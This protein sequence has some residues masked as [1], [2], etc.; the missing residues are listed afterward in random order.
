MT[1]S[2]TSPSTGVPAELNLRDRASYRIGGC[3]EVAWAI[4][5]QMA[6]TM[7]LGSGADGAQAASVSVAA[8]PG[9]GGG[10]WRS[11]DGLHVTLL[12]PG[13][14]ADLLAIQVT[15]VAST[16]ALDVE[17]RG[18]LLLHGALAEREGQGAVL[19]G[20]G[21]AGKSTASGRLPPPWRSLCDDTTLVVRD[22]E[23][24]YWAHPWPTWSRFLWG[25]PGGSW[26][27]Q[28]AVPLKGLFVLVQDEEERAEPVGAGRAATLL[29]EATEQ[30]MAA[31]QR[32]M[33]VDQRRA[34]RLRRFDNICALAKAV[35]CYELH[36]SLTGAFWEEM[37]RALADPRAAEDAA[38]R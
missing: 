29:V 3:D 9:R 20:P 4:V 32:D 38:G 37:E 25:G 28:R 5:A 10:S 13:E 12:D 21:M 31:M 33:T 26:D 2:G 16:I 1:D 11:G 23:G 30:V 8:R 19:A 35:P 15:E 14:S 34:I 24:R 36:L 7:M 18:G 27:V 22:A 6:E 17:K